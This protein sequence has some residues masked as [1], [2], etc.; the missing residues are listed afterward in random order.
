MIL[1]LSY[2]LFLLKGEWMKKDR[3]HLYHIDMK[4]I[5]DLAKVDDNVMSISPQI[6]KNTRPFVGVIVLCESQ[7]YCVPLTSPKAKHFNMKNDKD[8][9]KVYGKNN[10]LIGCLNF[11]N[12]IPVDEDV[13]K[14]VD[15]K[16][17]LGDRNEVKAYKNLMNDQL[18]WCNE[19]YEHVVRKAQK[20]YMLITEHPDNV[21][22][23]AKRC[24]DFKKLENVLKKRTEK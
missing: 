9:T 6:G 5:R 23:L 15:I 3:F 12:M 8:F 16:L 1:L 14:V 2:S 13:L 10:K 18:D 19:N 20:L 11:N 17:C 21:K 24:C 7:R 22:N 4:Y